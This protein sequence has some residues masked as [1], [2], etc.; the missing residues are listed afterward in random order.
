MSL[1]SPMTTM[2]WPFSSGFFAGLFVWGSFTD[3]PFWSMGVTTMKMIRSTST[4]STSGVTLMSALTL[5]LLSSIRDSMLLQEEVDEL[6][7]GVGHLDLEALETVR[8]VVE[9]HDRRDGDEQSER[10]RDQRLGDAGGDRA[11]SARAAGGHA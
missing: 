2:I 11:D 10:G 3:W 5:G 7:G 4:T 6:G 1:F 9:G 8:E